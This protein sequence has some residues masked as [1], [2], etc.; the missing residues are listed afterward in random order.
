MSRVSLVAALLLS[1]SVG[2]GQTGLATI[3]GTITD[4]SGASVASAPIEVHNS[5][6]GAVFKAASSESGNFTVP[7]LPVGDYDLTVSVAGFKKYSHTRFHLAA[8]Q[9]M[10]EDVALQVG[11]SSE[12]VT[13]T[14]DASLLQ[15][16][17]SEVAGNFTLTQLD[18]LP[19]L[20]VAATNDGVR[21]YF[22]ASRLLPGVQYCDTATCPGGGSGNAIT[23]TVINGTPSNTLTARL[24]G[25]T[26]NPTSS[27]LG[28]ATMETQ[29]STEAVQEVAILTSSFAPEFGAGGGAV[30]NVVTKS[31]TNQLHGTGYDYLVNTALNAAQPYTG[32]KNAIHQ[33]DYGFTVGGPVW[34]PKVYNGKNRTFFFF[35]FEEFYQNLINDTT[36]DTVP[37]AA[38]RSGN[39]SSLITDENRL[40]TTAS[41]AYVDPLGRTIQ[42]GTIFDPSS[43]M[44]VNGAQVRSPFLNNTIPLSEFDPVAVKILNLVPQPQGPLAAQAGSNYLAPYVGSRRSY[45]PSIKVDHNLG[46]KLHAAFYFQKTSTATPRTGTGADDL[47]NDITVSGTSSNAA[48]T[49]RLN[50]DH[51]VTP[52]L[53]IHYT[54]GW[55]DSDFLLGPEDFLNIQQTLGLTGATSPGR[56]LPL[57]ATGVSTNT[58]EG[59][60]GNLGP[61]YDQHFW[62]RRPSFVTS[63]T[64]VKGSHTF[65]VGAEIRQMKYPN[66]NFTYTAGEYTLR[67]DHQRRQRF[68][69]HHADLAERDHGVQWLRRIRASLVPARRR[70][71]NRRERAH[72]PH[73]GELPGSRVSPG[74][75]E[76][77][78]QIDS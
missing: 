59:G 11:Q 50:L 38:Y 43:T 53:L 65:K 55:N 73:D 17:T 35:S 14:A 7:Q 20:T 70:A 77:Q 9:T 18:D 39:F 42:S 8:D 26:M 31:G 13:V 69:L 28:G 63:A 64:Y 48:R 5:E 4:A 29:S 62:E 74:Q 58:A 67:Y 40:V 45:I 6:T 34:I 52:R 57:I 76:S 37:I 2:F 1:A 16:E 49:Y 72:Q 68:E 71:G 47:P 25:A 75:L 51:T 36:P 30:V 27:R 22:A 44:T 3:T 32:L 66:F 60:M 56:G 12:S 78:P 10:R 19:L 33:N 46:S 54:L 41:G 24:D 15:T 21:D 23:V 61:Q